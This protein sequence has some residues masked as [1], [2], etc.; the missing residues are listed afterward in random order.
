MHAPLADRDSAATPG[1]LLW[2]IWEVVF[3]FEA[4]KGQR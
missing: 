4:I 1:D 3:R 2:L